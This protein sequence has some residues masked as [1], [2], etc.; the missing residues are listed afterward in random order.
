M[1]FVV[2]NAKSAASALLNAVAGQ[3]PLASEVTAGTRFNALV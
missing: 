1:A 3:L 2:L